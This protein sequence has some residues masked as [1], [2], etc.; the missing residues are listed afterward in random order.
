MTDLRGKQ[1]REGY[2]F[3]LSLSATSSSSSSIG[4]E[5]KPKI[6][7][8]GNGVRTALR[9]GTESIESSAYGITGVS[10]AFI[11]GNNSSIRFNFALGD[12]LSFNRDSNVFNITVNDTNKL[13]ITSSSLSTGGLYHHRMKNNIDSTSGIAIIDYRDLNH[14][15]K[16]LTNNNDANGGFNDL[17]PLYISLVSGNV[18]FANGAVSI[19]H[20]TGE[21]NAN[22]NISISNKGPLLKLVNTT[23]NSHDFW[24]HTN[25][26]NFYVLTDRNNDIA[27][28]PPY[29]FELRNSTETGYIYG[30]QI[31]TNDI[32]LDAV[33]L[34]GIDS[35]QFLRSDVED[36]KTNGVLRFKN[37]VPAT[38]GNANEMMIY[39]N[40]THAVIGSFKQDGIVVYSSGPMY[41]DTNR[42]G[43]I[44]FRDASNGYA[45][46]LT[47]N[48]VSGVLVFANET[49]TDGIPN[50]IKL[51]SGTSE[52]NSYGFGIS[53][54]RLN[55]TTTNGGTHSFYSNGVL[56][57]EINSTGITSTNEIRFGADAE[58]NKLSTGRLYLRG[59]SPTIYFQDTGNGVNSSTGAPNDITSGMIHVNSNLMYFLRGDGDTTVWNALNSAW[60]LYLNLTNND[61]VFGGNVILTTSALSF[62]SRVASSPADLNKHIR[63]YSNTYGFS[64]TGGRLNYVA[65]EDAKHAFYINNALVAQIDPNGSGV[66]GVTS[67]VTVEKGDARYAQLA[68]VNEFTNRQRIQST[69]PTLDFYETD[70]S[71]ENRIWRII[72]NDTNFYIQIVNDAYTSTRSPFVAQRTGNDI[73]NILFYKG[74]NVLAARIDDAGTGLAYAQSVVTREKGDARY[75]RGA[76]S[77]STLYN[78][79]NKST[80]TI[81][82]TLGAI[83]DIVY[84]YFSAKVANNGY[85]AGERIQLGSWT[86]GD[87]EE[88]GDTGKEGFTV[89]YNSTNVY[90]N[91]GPK[92][93]RM[94]A[95]NTLSH[96]YMDP[97]QWEVGV[98]VFTI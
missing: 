85:A 88:S 92:Q 58:N 63:L 34:D 87:V 17:R 13:N 9:V 74:A 60:P 40:G 44:I 83:P 53:N 69:A 96:V 67:I 38:F 51:W 5:L 78:F 2:R 33:T 14:Y 64:I 77:E 70:V 45:T 91:F 54:G 42:G 98:K 31:I 61:A 27:H 22:S 76:K 49:T 36:E 18:Y 57:G 25:N 89:S 94:V 84:V 41:V 66:S 68:G 43:D 35:T 95:K 39:H 79:A 71:A 86:G 62:G 20:G 65:P 75:L 32:S 97:T 11:E 46:R 4:A 37:N 55:Y 48:M 8:D 81:P 56:L 72:A 21:L 26:N 3:L 10:G 19:D 12:F 6:I 93:I 29:P 80:V 73:S 50:R 52:T 47:L 16:L 15:Y 24:L 7:S 23:A 30:K 82:H 59:S 1:I 28:E 90:I